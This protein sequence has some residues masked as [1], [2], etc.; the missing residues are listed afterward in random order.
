MLAEEEGGGKGVVGKLLSPIFCMERTHATAEMARL[1][2]PDGVVNFSG[3]ILS[4]RQVRINVKGSPIIE[5]VI[6]TS[7][8]S[9]VG[10]RGKGRM[11]NRLGFESEQADL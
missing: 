4:P 2:R 5:G 9:G 1:I 10:G 8:G 7:E 6:A 3:Y 11:S